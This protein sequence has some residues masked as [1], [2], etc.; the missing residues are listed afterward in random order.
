MLHSKSIRSLLDSIVEEK[1]TIS[2][3]GLDQAGKT[4]IL[5]FIQTG[6]HYNPR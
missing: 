1:F 4:T 3:C 2:M 6:E 5:K